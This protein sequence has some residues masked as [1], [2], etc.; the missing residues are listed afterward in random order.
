MLFPLSNKIELKNKKSRK[1]FLTKTFAY[2]VFC[3]E[4]IMLILL[5]L[6]KKK[7]AA[8]GIDLFPLVLVGGVLEA[9]KRW[10]IGKEV[11]NYVSKDYP[12]IQSIRPKVSIFH[13][14]LSSTNLD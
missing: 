6:R 14:H 4:C 3:L 13:I 8:D 9:K 11:I 12:G 2:L 5:C 7:I 1:V 10:D